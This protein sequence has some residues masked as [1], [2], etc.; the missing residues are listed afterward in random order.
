MEA[1]R[2]L[3]ETSASSTESPQWIS[4]FVCI[5]KEDVGTEA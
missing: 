2:I 4:V 3:K 1:I 5:D